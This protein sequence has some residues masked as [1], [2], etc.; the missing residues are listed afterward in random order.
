M[1]F[2]VTGGAGYIGSHIVEELVNRDI[3]ITVLDNLHTGSLKNIENVKDGIKLEIGDVNTLSNI[4]IKDIDGIFHFGIPSSSPMY[5]ENPFLFANTI[6]DMIGILELA[7][8]RDPKIVFASSSSLYNEQRP[9]HREDMKIKVTDYYTETRLCIERLAILYNKLYG[10]KTIGLRLFSVYGPHEESKGK[11]ANLVSQF[12][13][14][15]KRGESPIIY[16]DGNQTR[17]FI[18]IKDVVNA[19]MLAME[20]NIKCDILNIGTGKSYTLN[21]LV[22][23]LNE[24]LNTS[25]K[26]KGIENPIKNYVQ[27]TLADT[28]KTERLLNFK[29]KYSLKNGIRELMNAKK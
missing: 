25:I 9:P 1:N 15:M 6:N 12:L 24:L 16:G 23:V 29:C 10:I 14:C 4:K 20:S 13:W 8:K 18:Y 2:L 17:D 21:E 22:N 3:E 27:H 5:K 7:R 19:S 26:A 11:Y 28:S